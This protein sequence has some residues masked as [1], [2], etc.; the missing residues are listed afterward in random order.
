MNAST[1]VETEEH[2]GKAPFKPPAGASGPST[3]ST[4]SRTAM[5]NALPDEHLS[6]RRVSTRCRS[7]VMKSL[8]DGDGGVSICARHHSTSKL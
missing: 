2:L 8:L 7:L 1:S 3:M 4:A 5:V 6:P